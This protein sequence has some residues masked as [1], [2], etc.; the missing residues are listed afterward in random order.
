MRTQDINQPLPSAAVARGAGAT[1][2]QAR[3]YKGWG[4]INHREQS[5]MSN[6]HGLQCRLN[7]SFSKGFMFQIAYTWSKAIDNADFT[8][9]IYGFVPNTQDSCGERGRANFDC[10]HNFICILRLGHSV[11]QEQQRSVRARSSAAGSTRAWSRSAP[12]CRSVPVTGPRHRRCGQLGPPAAAGAHAVPVLDRSVSEASTSG[13]TPACLRSPPAFG[14][15]SPISPERHLRTRLAI[16]ST[17]RSRRS[18][19]FTEGQQLE[20]RADGFNIFN[21]T[22][23]DAVGTTFF[24]PATFGRVTSARE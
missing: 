10:T 11:P 7:R 14:T 2:N 1:P 21:H 20:L 9:G 15:F 4:V 12:D 5:Y 17:C 22:Q 16:S 19:R 23:F 8:G 3:P 13:S 18:S 6:Y 24:T